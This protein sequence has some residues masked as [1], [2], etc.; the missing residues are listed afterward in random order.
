[1]NAPLPILLY[2]RIDDAGLSTSTPPQVFRQHL[3]L[4]KRSGWRSLS[5][6][7]FT[8]YM[9]SGRTLPARSF[10]ITFDDGYETV[11]SAALPVLRELGSSAIVFLA[12]QFMRGP[13]RGQSVVD[14][15][16]EPHK[17]MSWDQVRTLQGSGVIDC[18]SHSHAHNNFTDYSL[19]AM[20]DDLAT[21]VEL[22]AGELR[23][24]KYH[25]CHLAWPWGLSTQEWRNAA[26]EIGFTYQYGVSRLA[27]RQDMAQDDIPRTCFD[28]T[29]FASFQRQLWLQ[30][31]SFAPLWDIAYPFGKKLRGISRSL[32]A[33]A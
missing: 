11:A 12:T 10:L 18:Q 33:T 31:G 25:F 22:L 19:A 21:S 28:A 16:G 15:E 8:F 14:T 6:D 9:T 3:E 30:T 24:P 27:F 26:K 29:P 4:L 17:F 5:A 13:L 7:E 32:K 23:L 2:H 1:M 20:C